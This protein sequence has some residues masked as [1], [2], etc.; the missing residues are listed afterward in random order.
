MPTAIASMPER[1]GGIRE[2]ESVCVSVCVSAQSAVRYAKLTS[3]LRQFV[4][5]QSSWNRQSFNMNLLV[6]LK[7][8]TK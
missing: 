6:R 5:R 4:A 1:E 3:L 7:D 2:I 8:A